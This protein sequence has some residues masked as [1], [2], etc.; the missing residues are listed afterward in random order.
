MKLYSSL[1]ITLVLVS[2]AT[3]SH[4]Q[5]DLSLSQNYYQKYIFPIMPKNASPEYIILYST[6]TCLSCFLGYFDRLFPKFK[7]KDFLF[8]SS[9]M[10]NDSIKRLYKLDKN[11]FREISQTSNFDHQYFMR[12]E[13]VVLKINPY[14]NSVKKFIPIKVSNIDTLSFD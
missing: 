1:I 6:T 8:F 4:I 13:L 12:H 3:E 7:N 14:S 11:I 10:N 9:R 2:C 5:S